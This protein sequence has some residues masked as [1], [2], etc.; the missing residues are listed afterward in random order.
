MMFRIAS[1]VV[2]EINQ[3]SLYVCLLMWKFFWFVLL[4]CGV[5]CF[6]LLLLGGFCGFV[7]FSFYLDRTD[8]GPKFSRGNRESVSKWSYF[9]Q[10]AERPYQGL[11]VVWHQGMDA[12]KQPQEEAWP[13]WQ[14]QHKWKYSW[15]PPLE[16]ASRGSLFKNKHTHILPMFSQCLYCNISTL[17]MKMHWGF[18]SSLERRIWRQS[19]RADKHQAY[20]QNKFWHICLDLQMSGREVPFP[21]VEY[22]QSAEPFH[23][24]LDIQVSPWTLTWGGQEMLKFLTSFGWRAGHLF[25]K[26][27]NPCQ[28]KEKGILAMQ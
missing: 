23:P 24:E 1:V 17:I 9:N 21:W 28:V 8:W 10:H 18:S 4:V 25:I 6:F 27:A 5:V 14:H 13:K 3:W 20:L 19:W 7:F 15:E 11:N 16:C 2:T 22:L 26:G 12:G